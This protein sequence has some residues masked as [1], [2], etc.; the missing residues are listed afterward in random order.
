MKHGNFIFS[1][2]LMS[3]L[4]SGHAYAAGFGVGVHSGI[5][6][7]K[8]EEHTSS[9][10]SE[11]KLNMFLVGASAEYSFTKP[12]NFF[13]GITTDWAWG[14]E[15]DEESTQIM[16]DGTIVEQEADL[17][18]FSQF[19]DLRFGY[20]NNLKDIHYR[21]YASGGWDGVHF[22]RQNIEDFSL[23]RVGGG[24]NLVY[25]IGQYALDGRA[26]YAY[27]FDGDIRNSGFGGVWFDTNGTCLDMG[28]GVS[29]NIAENI[30][31]YVGGSYTSIK[32]D[33]SEEKSGIQFPE[34]ELQMFAGVINLTY[35]F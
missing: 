13:L 15:D 21:L 31:L 19:Y 16:S 26:A 23:W 2:L 7:M 3:I 32:L 35:S 29:R 34:S 11:A 1:F 10:N 6:L 12:K 22:D 5:G 9:F 14:L 18:I 28:I 24:I 30:S 20:K 33:K 8:Y 17:S 25:A 27:Y 4:I